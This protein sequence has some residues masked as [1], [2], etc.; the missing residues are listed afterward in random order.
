MGNTQKKPNVFKRAKNWWNSL[1]DDQRWLC[2]TGLW[3]FDGFLFGSLITTSCMEKKVNKAE[4]IGAC[5]GY[6]IGQIDAYKEIAKDPYIQMDIGMKRLESQ[7][8]VTKF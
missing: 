7:N 3:A 2:V 4:Q 1:T 8:K 6:V 5:K